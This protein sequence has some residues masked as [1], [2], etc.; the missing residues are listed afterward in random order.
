MKLN[1]Y[2]ITLKHDAGHVAIVVASD[3]EEKAIEQV[4]RHE[5]APRRAVVSTKVIAT[6]E[7]DKWQPTPTKPQTTTKRK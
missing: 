3:T 5:L 1:K 7:D 2:E 6:W 4:L